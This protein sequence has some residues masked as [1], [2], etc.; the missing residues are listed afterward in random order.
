MEGLEQ[1]RAA[2]VP[3]LHA[4][5]DELAARLAEDEVEAATRVAHKIAGSAGS[6]GFAEVSAIARRVEHALEAGADCAG[7]APEVDAMRSVVPDLA[8][9][10]DSRVVLVLGDEARDDSGVV[11]VVDPVEALAVAMD[12]RL[13]ALVVPYSAGPRGGRALLRSI[14]SVE[15]LAEVPLFVTDVDPTEADRVKAKTGA[16]EVFAGPFDEGILERVR[17]GIA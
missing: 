5:L 15:E 16:R 11:V 12:R 9:V 6:Y 1:L 13:A 7:Q 4:Q 14:A 10:D 2:Y 3:R 8:P 17:E